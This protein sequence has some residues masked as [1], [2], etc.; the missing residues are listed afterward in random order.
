MNPPA[1]GHFGAA[2]EV[3]ALFYRHRRLTWEMAKSELSERHSGQVLGALWS[4]IHPLLQI[5]LYLFMFAYV[6]RAALGNAG[7][8]PRDY[9][10]YILA[11]LIPW[12]SLQDALNK[13]TGA[14]H[15]HVSL[16]KQVVFPIEILPVKSVLV[17]VFAQAVSLALLAAYL[18]SR[19]ALPWSFVL[20]PVLVLMQLALMTGLALALSAAGAYFRDLKDIVQILLLAGLYLSPVFFPPGSLPRALE[21]VIHAN[22]FSYMVWCYQDAIYYGAAQHPAAWVVF[23]VLSFFGLSVGYRAFRRAKLLIGNLV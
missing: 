1:T 19:Q 11:G 18:V 4:V 9:A 7:S 2:R 16:V 14:I 5:G 21:P 20:V 12:I 3:L 6:F 8:F 13:S 23:P 10:T 15:A 17:T 22:P